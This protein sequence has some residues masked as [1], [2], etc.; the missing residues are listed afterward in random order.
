MQSS[1][2]SLQLARVT[3]LHAPLVLCSC[4]SQDAE[5]QETRVSVEVAG[6]GFIATGLMV[7][8]RN[9]LDVY[10]YANWG[11]QEALPVFTQG[12]QFMPASIDLREASGPH[13]VL[14]LLLFRLRRG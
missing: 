13:T 9:W 8:A 6:E 2:S 10:P 12:Q 1:G 5:G 11:G 4:C 14:L 7:T 3:L